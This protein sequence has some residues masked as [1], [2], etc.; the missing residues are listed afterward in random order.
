MKLDTLFLPRH[1]LSLMII[2]LWNLLI[3]LC[4]NP[5]IVQES[6]WL[7]KT[8]LCCCGQ[9]KSFKEKNLIS[10][11]CFAP[12]QD[13]ECTHIKCYAKLLHVLKD[14]SRYWTL[15]LNLCYHQHRLE[16]NGV[17][18]SMRSSVQEIPSSLLI[19]CSCSIK[20]NTRWREEN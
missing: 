15:I 2:L 16:I 14:Q 17:L 12:S 20:I 7:N 3:F 9:W 5:S 18:N 8:K 10:N 6:G 4:T 13:C 1:Q 11:Y 19:I